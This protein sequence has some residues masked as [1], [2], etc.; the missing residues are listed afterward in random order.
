MGHGGGVALFAER[1]GRQAQGRG[2][3]SGHGV[4]RLP[5]GRGVVAVLAQLIISTGIQ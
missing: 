3:E 5:L 4:C 1:I 2:V